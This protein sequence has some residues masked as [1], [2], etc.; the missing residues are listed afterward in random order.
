M[1]LALLGYG[2]MGKLI[3]N[4]A[5]EKGHTIVP[6]QHAD[7]ALDFS[8][9][10]AVIKHIKEAAKLQKPLVMGTTGWYDHLDEAKSIVKK[11][12]IGF[13][14][15]PNFSLGIQ[16]FLQ[17]VE[18]AA[19]IISPFKEYDASGVEYHHRQKV[20]NPSGTAKAIAEK[21]DHDL[22][23]ASVRCGSIPGTHTLIFDSPAD[24]I[25]FTHQARNREG[26]ALGAIAAAEWILNKKGFYTFQEMNQRENL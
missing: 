10:D 13:I 1:K 2:K 19:K 11:N 21:F 20:D 12:N 7:V 4:L 14:Y 15:S 8:H 17:I 23:F 24:T 6:L 3:E 22:H 18:A 25:T 5:L 16:L 9:P 26:F